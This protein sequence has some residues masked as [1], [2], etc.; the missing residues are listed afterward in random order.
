[1]VSLDPPLE[2]VIINAY[3]TTKVLHCIALGLRT[4]E[5]EFRERRD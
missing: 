1:M 3:K 5:T 2:K 4:A